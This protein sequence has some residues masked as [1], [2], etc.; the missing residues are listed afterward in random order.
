MQ[1]RFAVS[2]PLVLLALLAV[3]LSGCKQQ[4]EEKSASP[5]Q[6]EEKPGSDA[7]GADTVEVPAAGKKFDPPVSKDEIPMGAWMCDMGTVHYAR[8]EKGDGKCPECGM[9][10][11]HKMAEG[12]Q[13][14]HQ[15]G[16]HD[17]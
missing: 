12:A 3:P 1:Y 7:K 9:D 5:A 8:M 17:H 6:T 15:K 2:A 11:T 14:D 4:P 13:M 10:L 16:E